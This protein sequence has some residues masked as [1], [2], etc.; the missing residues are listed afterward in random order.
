PLILTSFGFEQAAKLIIS[1][2]WIEVIVAGFFIYAVGLK[3]WLIDHQNR[4]FIGHSDSG[5]HHI[6][7]QPLAQ[8]AV[9]LDIVAYRDIFTRKQIFDTGFIEFGVAVVDA[10]DH[11]I[12]AIKLMTE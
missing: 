3:N 10:C 2:A 12:D 9:D 8:I 6:Q 11:P 4:D 7:R 1:P 5:I